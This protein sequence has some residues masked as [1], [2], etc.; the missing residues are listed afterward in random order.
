[1]TVISLVGSF[2]SPRTL[3]P[4][5]ERRHRPRT[6]RSSRSVRRSARPPS[7]PVSAF[8]SLRARPAREAGGAASSASRDDGRQGS[9]GSPLVAPG[10]GHLNAH[11][12]SVVLVLKVVAVANL[13][14]GSNLLKHVT[15]Q[16]RSLLHD[17]RG[18]RRVEG[19]YPRRGRGSFYEVL[20]VKRHI[21][22]TYFRVFLIH[23]R[24]PIILSC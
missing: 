15:A 19:V 5:R 20:I 13:H 12:V 24:H 23:S 10:G 7:S 14:L 16:S 8:K 17:S 11:L 1:M 22:E 9:S 21:K 3:K 4:Y 18:N 2:I 6:K